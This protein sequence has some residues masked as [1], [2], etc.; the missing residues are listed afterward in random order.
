MKKSIK[1]I[2]LVNE[3]GT[4]KAMFI[5]TKKWIAKHFDTSYTSMPF[6]EL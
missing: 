6:S 2:R 4:I 3:C 5:L 1:I